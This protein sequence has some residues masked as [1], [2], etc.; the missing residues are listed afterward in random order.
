LTLSILFLTES[1]HP[2]LGGGEV[3]VRR[4]GA[5]L[6]AQGVRATVVTRRIDA[7]WPEEEMLDGIRIVRVGPAGVGA[8]GKYR[9]VPAAL[10]A[11]RRLR[12]E[13]DVLVVRGTRVLGLPGLRVGLP[14]VLQPEING[15]LSGE[16]YTWGKGW[17]PVRRGAVGVLTRM[18]NRS[19]RRAQ[20][21]VAM[22]RAIEDEMRAAGI[23]AGRI[24]RIPH[25]VDLTRFRPAPTAERDA[26]RARLALPPDATIVTY[27][28]RLLRGKG[29]ENLL[30]VFVALARE[31]ADVVLLLVGSGAGQTLSI[32]GSLRARVQEAG[33][34]K[35]VLFPGRVENV[36][37]YL[38]ASDV[39]VF[40]SE[41]EALGI[42]LVEAAAC[43][44]PCVASRTG[45]I[46]DVVEDGVT[47]LLHEPRDGA[48][49]RSALDRVLDD[50]PLRTR[51][52]AA[53][54]ART[55]R[56]YD[57]TTSVERYRRLFESLKRSA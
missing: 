42:S 34:A 12:G 44:L 53:A 18:R 20:A 28:G 41:F 39:F 45:G 8:S 47:G 27:T 4:L 26:L 9:M 35:R 49:L 38:R 5:A 1:F 11:V 6:A 31:R 21:F 48:G 54:R 17:G 23:E 55:E 25:G 33:L 46:V 51:L 32:E 50:G 37:D 43:G 10:K 30:E 29:L 19:L 57:W 14:A 3:H 7:A 15:E 52:G 13:T 40:P 24:H 2:V 16:A 36:D 22:S 56:E